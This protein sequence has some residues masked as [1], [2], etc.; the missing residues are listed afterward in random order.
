MTTR[1]PL[2]AGR[3]TGVGRRTARHA[4]DRAI[5][6]YPLLPGLLDNTVLVK[7]LFVKTASSMRINV[8]SMELMHL[9]CGQ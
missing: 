8:T 2:T 7:G 4:D 5:S 6:V 3:E 9:H 1:E